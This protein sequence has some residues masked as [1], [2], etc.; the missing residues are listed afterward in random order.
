MGR[1]QAKFEI[2]DRVKIRG[3]W[4][5]V[6]R[7]N[8]IDG[9]RPEEVGSHPAVPEPLDGLTD[10]KLKVIHISR[11]VHDSG[12]PE[13]VTFLHELMHACSRGKVALAYEEKFIADVEDPLLNAL[14]SL[15]WS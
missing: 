6:K 11:R 2:P 3:R 9:L 13:R 12:R 8:D 7:N 5:L 14:E 1:H 4:W 15:V 10:P